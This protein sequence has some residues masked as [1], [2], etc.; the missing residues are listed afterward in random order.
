[1]PEVDRTERARRSGLQGIQAQEIAL[2][3][4]WYMPLIGSERALIQLRINVGQR[5]VVQVALQ[6]S[7]E[8]S[9]CRRRIRRRVLG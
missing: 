9:L 5:A 8:R 3:A 2:L 4:A 7:R 1:M 6:R